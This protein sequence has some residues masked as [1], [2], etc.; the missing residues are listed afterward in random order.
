MELR[1]GLEPDGG[2]EEVPR[3]ELHAFEQRLL[4][5]VILADRELGALVACAEEAAVPISVLLFV[6]FNS[7]D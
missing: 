2:V 7:H 4:A 3:H 6:L 5:V 1:L